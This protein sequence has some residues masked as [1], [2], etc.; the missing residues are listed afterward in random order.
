V[1]DQLNWSPRHPNVQYEEWIGIYNNIGKKVKGLARFFG[2]A[3][4]VLSII[5]GVVIGIWQ[6]MVIANAEEDLLGA[7]YGFLMLLAF[8]G[9]G[10][11]LFLFSTWIL[12]AFGEGVDSLSELRK[13]IKANTGSNFQSDDA[14]TSQGYDSSS[15]PSY[16]H[17]HLEFQD[18]I[19]DLEVRELV[20]NIEM[21]SYK[22][23]PQAI[24]SNGKV[25]KAC[26]V[27]IISSALFC[28]S[29]G[30]MQ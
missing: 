13:T 16:S 27:Q 19:S 23:E 21:E 18:S 28:P 3:G 29:C 20:R 26:G 12:Y 5:A 17:L 22:N 1:S 6:G 15:N 24:E 10:S 4:I 9:G 11:L 2:V 30:Q 14:A 8:G 7:L 25:C